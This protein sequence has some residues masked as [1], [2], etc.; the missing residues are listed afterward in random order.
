MPR[1]AKVKVPPPQMGT[2]IETRPEFDIG[3]G[4]WY[5]KGQKASSAEYRCLMVLEKLGWS[6]SFQVRK[7]GGR[8]IAGG[9][10]LDI[11]VEQRNPPVYIDVRGYYHRG[12]QGEADDAKSIFQLRAA[13]P[14][15]KII[16]VW[17]DEA[18]NQEML[19]QRLL[20]EV[21][22]RGG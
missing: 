6:P 8:R 16:I 22:A 9:Q 1:R 19:Y 5:Y 10:V 18:K 14:D 13:A 7:F 15:V 3:E 20:R 11:L 17:D 4:P 2:Q 21:G 12:A